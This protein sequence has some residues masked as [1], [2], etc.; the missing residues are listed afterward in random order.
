MDTVKTFFFALFIFYF[1]CCKRWNIG[2]KDAENTSTPKPQ[3]IQ[4]NLQRN[5]LPAGN[6]CH[7]AYIYLLCPCYVVGA[8]LRQGQ[9][10]E[11]NRHGTCLVVF[12]THRGRYTISQQTNKQN[13]IITTLLSD[14]EEKK[15]TKRKLCYETLT[16]EKVIKE[17]FL[18]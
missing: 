13:N 9:S 11:Q 4:P 16:L 2:N 6:S 17:T 5:T 12:A 8:F 18:K 7:S 14:I 10:S 3:F 15:Y 1:I